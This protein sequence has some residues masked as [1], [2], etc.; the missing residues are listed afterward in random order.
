MLLAERLLHRV[1][2][3]VRRQTL[4]RRD[5]AP[6]RLNAEQRARL[7]RLAV[8]QNRARAARGRVAADVRTG[9][10]EPLA[11]HIDEQLARLE[12]ERVLCPVDR[13]RDASHSASFRPLETGAEHTP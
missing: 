1:E 6:V 7:H 2:R 11:Q 9:K 8:Q 5:L 10:S 12:L 13:D 3:P 4:D